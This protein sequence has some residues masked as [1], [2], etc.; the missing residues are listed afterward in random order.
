MHVLQVTVTVMRTGACL[1]GNCHCDEGLVHV[2]QVTV[3]VMRD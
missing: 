3:T 2:S 1:T